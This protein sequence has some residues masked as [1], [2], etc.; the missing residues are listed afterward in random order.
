MLSIYR[1]HRRACPHRNQ[2]R[3]YRRCQCPIWADGFLGGQEIRKSL[4]LRDWARA[5]DKVREWEAEN[6]QTVEQAQPVTLSE[7]TEKFLADAE[8]RKLNE[9]TIY[10]Y[11]LLFSRL[12]DFA[13]R[14]GLRFLCEL[15]DVDKLSQFRAEWKD[16]P[17]SSLKKLERL[18]AFFHF[19]ERRKWVEGNPARELKAPKVTLRPTMP[20]T[21]DE[22]IA[23]LAAADELLS[24]KQPHGKDNARRLRALI[25]LL[26][27]SGLRISDAVR[28]STEQIVDGKLRLYTQKTGTPVYCPLP[29]FVVTELELIPGMSTRFWFWTGNGKLQTAVC[30]WQARLLEVFEKANIKGGH[31]HRFR[32]TFAVE[33]LLAGVPIERVS[34]LLG[35]S[36]IRVT[37]KHYSPWVK[38][39]QDQAEADVRRTWV[40]DPVVLLAGK[41]TPE[42]HAPEGKPN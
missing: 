22:M 39:R 24:E 15:A 3:K 6:R 38:A 32:D 17:R 8:A 1:R 40:Q 41:G 34:V 4:G 27:Y 2:G 26:R 13:T 25:L 18:W 35:H 19:A 7:A 23:I 16:G 9:S 28:C 12:K 11:K 20:F 29:D 36:S 37:E 14:L 31:A 21:R 30:D 33:L 42:V 10:K 5:Q